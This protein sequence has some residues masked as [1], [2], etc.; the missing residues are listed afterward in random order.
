MPLVRA[1]NTNP[2]NNKLQG[3]IPKNYGDTS[4]ALHCL[5][6]RYTGNWDY[7]IPENNKVPG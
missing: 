2:T 3:S 7:P 4:T 6:G 5:P 1:V